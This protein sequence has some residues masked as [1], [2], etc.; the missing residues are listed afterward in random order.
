MDAKSERHKQRPARSDVDADPLD[1]FSP[2][3]EF[4]TSPPKGRVSPPPTRDEPFVRTSRG[5]APLASE[6][7]RRAP[8]WD[9]SFQDANASDRPLRTVGTRPVPPPSPLIRPGGS[10]AD[11][12]R[13]F[14]MTAVMVAVVVALIVPLILN[15]WRQGSGSTRDDTFASV[16][17]SSP[18]AGEP[19]AEPTSRDSGS[20]EPVAEPTPRDS[21]SV[22][23]VPEPTPRDSGSPADTRARRSDATIAAEQQRAERVKESLARPISAPSKPVRGSPPPARDTRTIEQAR[24]AAVNS[25]TARLAGSVGTAARTEPVVSPPPTPAPTPPA[26][27]P[28]VASNTP[29]PPTPS[30]NAGGALT[31]ASGGLAAPPPAAP[32]AAVN[33]ANE[34]SAAPI[35]RPSP[36]R[37]TASSASI[38]PPRSQSAMVQGV[39]NQYRDAFNALDSKAAQA[40]WP[41]APVKELGKAFASLERQKLE[42]GKCDVD[43]FGA[44][45]VAKCGGKYQLRPEGWRQERAKR[46]LANG[47]SNSRKST[48]AGRSTRS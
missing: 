5:D 48:T 6:S 12:S 1:L 13:W 3:D 32:A 23:P 24:A 35:D 45:A 14:G 28:P 19:V 26:P 30:T 44:R 34:S 8:V 9:D 18:L 20:A 2:E 37:E 16:A 4:A 17:T 29:P 39:L 47:N 43:F 7:L 31:E 22:D 33:A 36:P 46:S 11:T 21:G 25:T 42:L 27:T 10:N 15:A 40:A 41:K 38:A